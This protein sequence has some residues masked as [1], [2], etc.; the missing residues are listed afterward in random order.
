MRECTGEE[1][2]ILKKG[3]ESCIEIEEAQKKTED[4]TPTTQ[5]IRW[6]NLFVNGKYHDYFSKN[7][8]LKQK[9]FSMVNNT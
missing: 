3:Y 7:E 5:R 6:M 8:E 4:G 1:Q 2:E 9:Y